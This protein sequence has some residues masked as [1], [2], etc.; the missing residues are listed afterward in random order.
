MKYSFRVNIIWR[1]DCKQFSVWNSG[2]AVHL[3][4]ELKNT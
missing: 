4:I 3:K 1:Y 2:G